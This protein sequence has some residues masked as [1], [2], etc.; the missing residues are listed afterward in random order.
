MNLRLVEL[1]LPTFEALAAG[2]FDRAEALLGLDIPPSFMERNEIWQFFIRMLAE[3][4]DAA[5]WTMNAVV[6]GDTI[7]GNAGFKGAPDA[8][9][10]VE[11]GYG[12]E[13]AHLRRGYAIAAVRLLLE[14]A[15][16]EPDVRVVKAVVNPDNVASIAVVTRAEFTQQGDD[17]HPRHGRRLLFTHPP[18]N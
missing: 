8:D 9:G 18:G 17:M 7:V 15:G 13:P 10:M 12:T 16:V 11:I 2:D 14:R 4:P 5:G 1:T 6:D 3:H